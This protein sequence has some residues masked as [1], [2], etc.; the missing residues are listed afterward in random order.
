CAGLSS[1]HLGALDS[2]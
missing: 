1:S 2:W